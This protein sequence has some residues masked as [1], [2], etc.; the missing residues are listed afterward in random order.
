[1]RNTAPSFTVIWL[2][3]DWVRL[4]ANSMSRRP[5][6]AYSAYDGNGGA[7][8]G[9][10]VKNAEAG[11]RFDLLKSKLLVNVAGFA[12]RINDRPVNFGAAIQNLLVSPTGTTSTAP[13]SAPSSKPPPTR[14]ASTSRS[15]TSRCATC[16]STS[17]FSMNDVQIKEIAPFATPANP[18]P[19]RL[20]A[21]QRFVAAGGSSSRYLGKPST[22]IS[23]YTGTAFVRYEF[24]HGPSS[25]TPGSCSPRSTSANARR[26]SSP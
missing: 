3:V 12:M 23:K 17:A 14:R 6:P 13:A 7:L 21:Q 20:A 24:N 9:A 8:D 19:I 26:N 5:G 22:D 4:Y 11:V 15:T 16:A 25:K 1:V 10:T 2:P 18:D